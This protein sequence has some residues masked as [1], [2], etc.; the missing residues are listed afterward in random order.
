MAEK[1]AEIGG[2]RTRKMLAMIDANGIKVGDF[3]L[4]KEEVVEKFKELCED[5]EKGFPNIARESEVSIKHCLAI[6]FHASE[7][8][9][10]R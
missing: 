10:W 9:A 8:V 6:R 5:I 7:W 2:E 4:T 1:T 3:H